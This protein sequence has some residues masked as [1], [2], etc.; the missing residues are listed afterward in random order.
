MQAVSHL[1]K[2]S[3][4]NYLKDL[5]IPDS[6]LGK[7]QCYGYGIRSIFDPGIRDGKIRIRDKHPVSATL[8]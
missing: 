1:V 2:E 7:N 8:I 5:P 4:P 3:L 6:V